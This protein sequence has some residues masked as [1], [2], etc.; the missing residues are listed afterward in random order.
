VIWDPA[1]TKTIS[2]KTQTS[3]IDYNV[4]E[5]IACT[6]GPRITLSGGRIAWQDGELRAEKGDGQFIARPPFPASHV[7]NSTWKEFSAPRPV[8]RSMPVVP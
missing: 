5:G 2:A 3:R 4:F 6:G 8:S 7:A 1:K